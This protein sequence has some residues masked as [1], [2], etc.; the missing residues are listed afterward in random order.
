MG[1]VVCGGGC[2]RTLGVFLREDW[3]SMMGV[4]KALFS[5]ENWRYH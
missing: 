1:G 5:A 3:A 4:W 2:G